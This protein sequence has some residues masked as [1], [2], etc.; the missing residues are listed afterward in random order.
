MKIDYI[1]I[2][3]GTSFFR[4][5]IIINFDAGGCRNFSYYKCLL[6]GKQTH[7]KQEVFFNER[8]VLLRN[9]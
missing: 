1:E 7:K 6:N 9:K 4:D 2:D 8:Y 5:S 3:I